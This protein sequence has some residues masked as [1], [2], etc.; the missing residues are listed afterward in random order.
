VDRARLLAIRAGLQPAF[1]LT[2][3]EEDSFFLRLKKLS[4]AFIEQADGAW[5]VNLQHTQD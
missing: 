1:T 5:F 3:P 4:P 2:K